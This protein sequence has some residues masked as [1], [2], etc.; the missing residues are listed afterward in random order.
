MPFLW[1]RDKLIANIHFGYAHAPP[2]GISAISPR[3]LR[4]IVN[5]MSG[6]AVV[7]A[8]QVVKTRRSL[9]RGC[10]CVKRDSQSALVGEV[11]VTQAKK[12][13]NVVRP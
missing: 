12:V 5:L 1:R 6:N 13:R 10:E 8:G 3:E 9:V 7:G 4:L 2:Q 11:I